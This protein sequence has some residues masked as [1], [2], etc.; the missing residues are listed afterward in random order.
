[1][2]KNRQKMDFSFRK[3]RFIYAGF[4]A[5]FVLAA[6]TFSAGTWFL[7]SDSSLGGGMFKNA[8]PGVQANFSGFKAGTDV[9]YRI[10]PPEG[11]PVKG[12]ASTDETGSLNIPATPLLQSKDKTLAYNVTVDDGRRI[13]DVLLNFDDKGGVSI[14]G[15]GA[16][17]FEKIK[18][19]S[20]AGQLDIYSDWAGIFEGTD[21]EALRGV[22]GQE[23]ALQLAFN[24]VNSANDAWPG[25]GESVISV[26]Y[27][28][29][30]GMLNGAG[31]N[32]F[33]PFPYCGS[34][35]LSICD[36]PAMQSQI[37][38]L[39]EN[40]IYPMLHMSEQLSTAIAQQ[41]PLIGKLIDAKDQLEAQ[42]KEQELKAVAVKDYHPSEQMCKFGSFIRS[43][44]SAK[45]KAESD[46]LSVSDALM[47]RYTNALSTSTA[48]NVDNDIKNRLKQFREIYCDPADNNNGLLGLCEHD[49]DDNP[50]NSTRGAAA[51]SG[52]GA[53]NR[54]RINKDIDFLRTVESSYTLDVDF[55]DNV[56]TADEQDVMALAR[57]LYWPDPYKIILQEGMKDKQAT[58]LKARRIMALKNVAHNSFATLVGLKAKAPIPA[59]P[60]VQ[61]GWSYMKTMM[62]D[63]G[64]TDVDIETMVGDR[65]SYFAQMDMLS[66]RIFQNPDF[67][68]NLYDKPA[69]IS[70]IKTSMDAI[71]IM[72]MRDHYE[73]AL[74][75][76]MLLSALI[77]ERLV[78][79][80]EKIQGQMNE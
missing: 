29:G 47:E 54:A 48:Q 42:R 72:Q 34:P 10:V 64:M 31:L 32:V 13:L 6:M 63:F 68:T 58:Y 59:S 14:H 28:P 12:D 78:A 9:S 3:F 45:A 41:T 55:A 25:K 57:N 66:K 2:L 1:M 11:T 27:A 65:P 50:G 26:I 22:H 69:N 36:I 52:I 4:A 80:A 61:P 77:E 53:S 39:I 23:Q 16:E 43:L 46:T 7:P 60:T 15:R 37:A 20:K 40:L 17:P 71:K 8:R 49:Q 24:N 70:R 73:A 79:D 38:N 76:E 51:P 19:S 21:L 74:R 30:G 56:L 33:D 5:V 67:Y 44:P 35:P 18:I 75:R 62:R